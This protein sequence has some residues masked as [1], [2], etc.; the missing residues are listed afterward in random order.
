MGNPWSLLLLFAAFAWVDPALSEDDVID[1]DF[2]RERQARS[3]DGSCN[4]AFLDSRGD[5]R[6]TKSFAAS[7]PLEF[8]QQFFGRNDSTLAV[9]GKG[10]SVNR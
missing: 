6:K 7:N 1:L 4:I 5:V 8:F 10:T 3:V 9:G 2:F